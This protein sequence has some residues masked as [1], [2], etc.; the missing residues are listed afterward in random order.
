MTKSHAT[1]WGEITLMLMIGHTM[2]RQVA[3]GT[4]AFPRTCTMHTIPRSVLC[5]PGVI[6][7]S[8]N[9]G[10]AVPALRVR[11]ESLRV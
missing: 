8:R 7:G 1:E 3:A 5:S 2:T 4:D 9:P 11:E 6:L 10:E